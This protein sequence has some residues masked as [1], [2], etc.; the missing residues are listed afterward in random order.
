MTEP[1][2]D[3][4]RPCPRCGEEIIPTPI[5]Y[6]YP[7]VD[8]FLEAEAGSIRLGGCMVGPESPEFACP[9][10]DALLPWS[11]RPPVETRR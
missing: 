2:I 5:R 1:T 6:G 10:C 3:P 8:M 7:S 11:Q 9:A 4:R